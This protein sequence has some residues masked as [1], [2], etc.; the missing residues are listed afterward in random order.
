MLLLLSSCT[1]NRIARPSDLRL[2]TSNQHSAALS[3]PTDLPSRPPLT[4]SCIELHVPVHAL[5][6]VLVPVRVPPPPGL[7]CAHCHSTV[8]NRQ[9]SHPSRA[10]KWTRQVKTPPTTTTTKSTKST[11]SLRCQHDWHVVIAAST[12]QPALSITASP[13]ISSVRLFSRH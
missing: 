5:V 12:S 2:A 1:S 4:A 11:P 10:S 13:L 7:G 6:P 3:N 8:N 9:R